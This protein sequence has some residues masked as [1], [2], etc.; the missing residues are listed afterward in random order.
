MSTLVVENLS[1]YSDERQM[2]VETVAASSQKMYGSADDA[3]NARLSGHFNVSSV[4]DNGS[5]GK[6][7]NLTNNFN[8]TNNQ[9]ARGYI[10]ISAWSHGAGRIHRSTSSDATTRITARYYSNTDW[11]DAASSVR[12]AGLL[13]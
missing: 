6:N 1:G 12:A 3:G 11:V 7:Y 10:F 5:N 4:T 8:G 9:A 13:A 2:P